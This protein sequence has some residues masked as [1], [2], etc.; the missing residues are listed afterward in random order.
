M[1]ELITKMGYITWMLM[2]NIVSMSY[3]FLKE[4]CI[5]CHILLLT[6]EGMV[7]F[8][9]RSGYCVEGTN[10]NDGWPCR[11]QTWKKKNDIPYNALFL[12]NWPWVCLLTLLHSER[13]KLYTFGL[14][15]CNR[16]KQILNQVL[17]GFIV[18]KVCKQRHV[19]LI[20]AHVKPT[21]QICVWERMQPV[22]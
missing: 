19:N 15:E 14:S 4:I 18:F 7:A 20:L 3:L 11:I 2:K 1:K 9:V 22:T 17:P 12:V 6:T 21:L 10:N 13:P 16:V 5:E 8:W